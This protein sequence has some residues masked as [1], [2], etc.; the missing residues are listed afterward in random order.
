MGS[1]SQIVKAAALG[2]SLRPLEVGIRSDH[3]GVAVAGRVHLGLRRWHV[4]EGRFACQKRRPNGDVLGPGDWAIGT[5]QVARLFFA[6]HHR[7]FRIDAQGSPEINLR[8]RQ[9]GAVFDPRLA[10]LKLTKDL[11]P[12]CGRLSM[13]AQARSH[14]FL[15]GGPKIVEAEAVSGNAGKQPPIGR[16][17]E[18]VFVAVRRKSLRIDRMP[19]RAPQRIQ[20]RMAPLHQLANVSSAQNCREMSPLS[21]QAKARASI[22]NVRHVFHRS[23]AHCASPL[24]IPRACLRNPA[25]S[26]DWKTL[27]PKKT[28]AAPASMTPRTTSIAPSFRL[29]P[30]TRI[31][32]GQPSTTSRMLATLPA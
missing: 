22:Q 1:C 14:L 30:R 13:G 5:A 19:L 15:R 4:H 18:P 28:P 16:S 9:L 7:V 32:S 23:E 2:R 8:D 3:H 20:L 27:R 25:M 24:R 17:A 21:A 6:I 29:P 10:F 31:G 26:W 11:P 12:Y